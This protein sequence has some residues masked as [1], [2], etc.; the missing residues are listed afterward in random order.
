[1]S[2][3]PGEEPAKTSVPVVLFVCTANRCRSPMAAAL[4]ERSLRQ[5]ELVADV[6]SAGLLG[7]GAS[8]PDEVLTALRDYEIDLTT[9][10]SHR[11][12]RTDITQ[13]NLIIGL[14]RQHVREA[15]L[16]SPRSE[17]WNRT[18]T[19]RELVRRGDEAGPRSPG[20][21]LDT[22]LGELHHGRRSEELLGASPLD[23]VSDP[24]GKSLSEY[25][26]TAET[27]ADLV[28]AL[29]TLA[30]PLESR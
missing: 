6:R 4:F 24:F 3:S 20:L 2:D 16:A 8:A 25:R 28:Q 15:V 26:T 30:F 13:A 18:F 21:P 29:S 17:A 5:R 23:D 14:E 10:R 7:G 22:W 19:L 12:R 27:L 11:L 9:H 1:M